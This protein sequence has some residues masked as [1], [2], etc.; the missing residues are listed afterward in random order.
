MHTR[1]CARM[2]ECVALLLAAPAIAVNRW[3][4]GPP[5]LNVLS[6]QPQSSARRKMTLSFAARA[7]AEDITARTKTTSQDGISFIQCSLSQRGGVTVS[8]G[9]ALESDS[10][11]V[12]VCAGCAV[13]VPTRAADI[14][15]RKSGSLQD[16]LNHLAL[17]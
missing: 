4:D 12:T 13:C 17:Y 10:V 3:A 8:R 2:R 7:D 14:G 15:L 5:T 11:S 1:E 9:T 16:L 6:P